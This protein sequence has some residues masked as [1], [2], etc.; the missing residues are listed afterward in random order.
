[1]TLPAPSILTMENVSKSFVT[2]H[3]PVSVL[4][5][6]NMDL[7]AGEFAAITG[8][9][10]SG[11]TTFLN[12]ASL[13]D[14]P[15]AGTIRFGTQ[16]VSEFGEARLNDL[17]KHRIG[18]VFQRFCLMSRRTVL[19]NVLFRFRYLDMPRVKA[20]QLARHALAELDLT[21]HADRP[22]RLLSGG[23]MQRTAIARAVALPPDLLLVDEPTGNLDRAAAEGVMQ[24]FQALNQRG[25]AIVLATHNTALL[26]YCGRRFACHEGTLTDV[27]VAE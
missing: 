24:C 26:K 11:K 10:G 23:E 12:L 2:P 5:S 7:R 20:L 15:T 19:E 27:P 25:I 21:R 8:P 14:R 18:M 3:G 13:L 22:A 9:S 6:V 17:R 16:N 1:M 4:H